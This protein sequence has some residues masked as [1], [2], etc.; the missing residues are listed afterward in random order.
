VSRAEPMD[1]AARITRY[2]PQ[3]GIAY[4]PQRMSYGYLTP[5]QRRRALK[6]E[7]Q[8]T[9]RLVG[10]PTPRQRKPRRDG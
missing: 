3:R 5:R 10:R 1:Y 2:L 6:K 8:A 4:D 9:A 7:R